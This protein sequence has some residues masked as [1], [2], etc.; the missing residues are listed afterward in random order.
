[1]TLRLA[2][3]LC[4]LALGLSGGAAGVLAAEL[5]IGMTQ[6]PSTLNPLIDSM[7]AKSYVL[8][9][10][11]RPFTI[12]DQNWELVCM[13][14]TELPTI[15]NGLAK[16]EDL[17]DGKR[18][19][20]VT[21]TIQPGATW[22]DGKPVT[23]GDVVFTWQV[24]RHPKSGV[25]DLESFRRVLSIDVI[26]DKTFTLHVDRIEFNY[27]AMPFPVLP[28]HIERAIFEADPESY[29]NRTAF[30]A[31][32]TNP[33][34]GFGPYRVVELVTGA[35]IVLEPSPTWWGAKPA[36]D[37]VTI[38][39]IEKT[40]ALEANLLSGAIDMIAG[41][42]GLSLDQ[43]LAFEK[44]H[45]GRF[46]ITYKSGLIYEHLDLNLDNPIL[47][48][49]RVRKALVHALDRET[50]SE[51]LFAGRQ[52]VAHSSVSPLDWIYDPDV[53]T[54]P[55]DPDQAKALL[56]EAGWSVIEKGIRYNTAGQRLTLEL[57]TTA[58][59]RSRELV[60]QVLQSQWR[61]VGIDVRIRNEQARVF[62]GETVAKRKFTGA[63]MFAWLS[64]PESV[65]RTTLRSDQIPT[66]DNN[67]SGQNYTGFKNAGMDD[68]I[69]RIEVEL[70]RGARKELWGRLQRLYA[71]ELP[72]IPLYWRAN[73][74]I[75]P[76]WLEGVRPT[77]HLGTT[78]LWIEEW[79]DSR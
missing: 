1:M 50:L 74:Y 43:A 12:Y 76:K 30:D 24:G 45:G 19:I 72:V 21:Y 27:N 17:P 2:A 4:A 7:L 55:Y 34:L 11:R 73:A 3:L 31:D 28:A 54:Y 39:V 16:P 75:L 63:A 37:R 32:P 48:D 51:R 71:E 60:E 29:R 64:A 36:F 10:T 70:D 65:P 77:G 56:D 61:Q 49:K 58:G 41:E 79:R 46:N 23:S 18:G 68:L 42:L 53:P 13:L 57:M 59:N 35:R 5:R 66:A 8:A 9:M 67:W 15:E 52:P 40:T 62:F 25:S 22:G 38:R 6:F 20:A 78:T 44:R 69:D 14:C 33:G 26:D 47:A